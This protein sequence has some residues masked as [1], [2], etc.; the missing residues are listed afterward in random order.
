[1]PDQGPGVEKALEKKE[2]IALP[3][4]VMEKELTDKQRM[5]IMAVAVSGLPRRVMRR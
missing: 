3:S 2:M 1:M 5:A 4:E